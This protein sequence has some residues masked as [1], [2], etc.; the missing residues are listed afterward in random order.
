MHLK[1]KRSELHALVGQVFNVFD[2]RKSNILISFCIYQVLDSELSNS[3][4]WGVPGLNQSAQQY[5]DEYLKHFGKASISHAMAG[6]C[7]C[8]LNT[9][10]FS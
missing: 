6:S 5:N 7:L 8:I 4:Q 3:E 1:E 2:A 9:M 10:Q